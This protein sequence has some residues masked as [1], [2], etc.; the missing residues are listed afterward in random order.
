MKN[1]ALYNSSKYLSSDYTEVFSGI[2]KMDESYYMSIMFE[3][4][5]EYDEGEDASDISQYP[6]EDL[7]DEFCVYISD[8]YDQENKK[9]NKQCYIELCSPELEDLIEMQTIIGKHVINK[10]IIKDGEE[11]IDLVIE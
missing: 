5:P 8:F 11:V 3:Q 10:V 9:G 6:L 4:E 7:L 2:Y 1:I